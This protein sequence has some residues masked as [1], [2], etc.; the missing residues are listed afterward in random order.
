MRN[1]GLQWNPA[2]GNGGPFMAFFW[3]TR[4]GVSGRDINR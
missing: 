2:Q 3:A 1:D 4:N